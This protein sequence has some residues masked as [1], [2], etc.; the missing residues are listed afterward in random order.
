MDTSASISNSRPESVVLHP[1]NSR[2]VHDY[3][4]DKYRFQLGRDTILRLVITVRDIPV[5]R[6]PV[7]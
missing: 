6:R 2:P 3:T 7:L 4:P 5:P 1:S